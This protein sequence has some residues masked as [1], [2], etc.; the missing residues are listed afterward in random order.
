M[1]NPTTGQVHIDR[2]MTNVSIAYRNENYIATQIF[3]NVPVQKI[4]DY[5]FT[6]DKSD[7]FRNEAGLR[8]PGTV[9]PIVEYSLSSAT[10]SCKPI[11]AGM[12]VADEVV[13]NADQ[14]L[15]PRR[16]ATVFTTDKVMLY[17]EVEVQSDV[18][19]TGWASSATP[20][21]TW[22]DDASD[23]IANVEVGRETVV[24]LIG[25][26]PNVMVLGREVW[27][28]LKHHPD[29]L[30]RIKYTSTGQMT[31]A[32]LANLFEVPKVL[33]G[34][35]IYDS[36]DEGATESFGYIWGKHAWLGYVSPAPSLMTPSAGYL[37]TWQNRSVERIR[38][39]INKADLV[40][41]EWHYDSKMTATDAG[42]LFKS[43]VA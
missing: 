35:A 2:A 23:P 11:S 13:R 31:P 38:Q 28:D 22:D 21:T 36:A 1:A 3:P 4:S 10:Y 24:G 29:L 18:F 12:W 6:F 15:Q 40:R 34:N 39:D 30:D 43:C 7:W 25:R 26:E 19:G 33:I 8:A 9:G 17:A 5:Y 16:D 27:T 32:L 37:F 42:Y 14:P 41:T 20:V